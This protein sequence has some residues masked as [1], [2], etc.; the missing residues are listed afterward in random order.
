M[1]I[2]EKTQFQKDLDKKDTFVRQSARSTCR[3]ARE[4][5]DNNK[6][7]WSL[8]PDR[9]LAVLNHDVAASLATITLN[10]QLL[11]GLMAAISV[12]GSDFLRFAGTPFVREDIVFDGTAFV[13][14]AP[15][16]P[17]SEPDAQ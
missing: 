5:N 17:E 10:T 9:L 13:Y 3:L 4:L 12:L 16:E 1:I 2:T 7:F 15:P 6:A 14:V 11:Q 8:P